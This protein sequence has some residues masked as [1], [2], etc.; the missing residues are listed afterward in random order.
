[1]C[2]RIKHTQQCRAA[3]WTPSSTVLTKNYAKFKKT[4]K[5]FR[6]G[7]RIICEEHNL[8]W[9]ELLGFVTFI[10]FSYKLCLHGWPYLGIQ[11]LDKPVKKRALSVWHTAI[12]QVYAVHWATLSFVTVL[13]ADESF[14]TDSP[15]VRSGSKD[16]LRV[17]RFKTQRF[18]PYPTSGY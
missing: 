9:L 8:S 13:P 5:K 16:K 17:S 10:V 7:D 12:S 18:S 2:E 1:M 3:Q 11:L 6:T 15:V 4:K 14:R